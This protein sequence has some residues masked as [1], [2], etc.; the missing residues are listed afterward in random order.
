MDVCILCWEESRAMRL[1]IYIADHC[2]N[3]HEALRLAEMARNVQGAEVRVINLDTTTEAIPPRII[4]TPMYLLDGRI[5][6]MGNPYP[7]DLM[8]MLGKPGEGNS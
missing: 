6:S 3:C 5:V 1:E 7:D 4:A 2:E 8:R